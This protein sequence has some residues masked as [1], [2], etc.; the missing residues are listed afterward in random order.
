[1]P[2]I[3]PDCDRFHKVKS[4]DQCESIASSNGITLDQL[5]AWNTEINAACSNL[6]LDFYICTHVPGAVLPSATTSAPTPSNSPA[7]PGAVSDCNKWHKIVPSDTCEN[8]SAKNRI[9]VGQFRD[10]NTKLNASMSIPRTV[11]LVHSLLIIPLE[12]V[13]AISGW[14]TTPVSAF[15]APPRPCP[16]LCRT[17]AV[18]TWLCLAMHVSRLP[19]RVAS[20]WPISG[21][22]TRSSTQHV[23]ICGSMP[24]FA[25]MHLELGLGV[26]RAR[27]L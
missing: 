17:A 9:T 7:L 24:W 21:A 10:W 27:Y 5:R 14:T 1:M 22:G 20:P 3:A 15:R 18:T 23:Q 4:G 16:A 2:G 25:Q 6:W 12:Q 19:R 11:S 8:I 26:E 13:A